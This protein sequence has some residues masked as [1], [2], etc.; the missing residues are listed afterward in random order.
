[1]FLFVLILYTPTG[2]LMN[3]TWHHGEGNPKKKNSDICRV[4][5][6]HGPRYGLIQWKTRKAERSDCRL[7]L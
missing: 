1:M 3:N 5:E 2:P 4:L 7:R 6:E